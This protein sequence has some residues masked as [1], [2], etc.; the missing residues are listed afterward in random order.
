MMKIK[1]FH[2]SPPGSLQACVPKRREL[3]VKPPTS[4]T[5]C[6]LCQAA[7]SW[8]HKSMGSLE[9]EVWSV[10]GEK[11]TSGKHHFHRRKVHPSAPNW[12]HLVSYLLPSAI[13]S[14][15]MNEMGLDADLQKELRELPEHEALCRDRSWKKASGLLVNFCEVGGHF[16]F[17]FEF[18]I[19]NFESIVDD[20]SILLDSC[21]ATLNRQTVL[22]LNLSWIDNQIR[23]CYRSG[24]KKHKQCVSICFRWLFGGR[25]PS[26]NVPTPF[27][28]SM[29][30]CWLLA[31]VQCP[32]KSKDNCAVLRP[33]KTGK[34]WIWSQ[35]IQKGQQIEWNKLN[36]SVFLFYLIIFFYNLFSAFS[37]NIQV[38]NCHRIAMATSHFFAFR[39]VRAW[40]KGYVNHYWLD[41]SKDCRQETGNP[42][43]TT[44][45]QPHNTYLMQFHWKS[46]DS[47]LLGLCTNRSNHFFFYCITKSEVDIAQHFSCTCS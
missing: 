45:F 14:R 31:G 39:N 38:F 16:L 29:M 21:F 9:L 24:T 34:K 4:R 25:I 32:S 17:H 11:K 12:D 1:L 19:L 15:Q 36:C 10:S 3:V 23:R 41:E 33:T 42:E 40:L 6:N 22:V 30:I 46:C 43:K 26:S 47:I 20:F 8:H 7:V 2:L 44:L 5:F 35:Q 13:F 37:S 27:S 28:C 18:W